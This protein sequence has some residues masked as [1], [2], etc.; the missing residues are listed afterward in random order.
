MVG[1]TVPGVFGMDE[2]VQDAQDMRKTTAQEQ[3]LKRTAA[4]EMGRI[5]GDADYLLSLREGSRRNT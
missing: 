2:V 5:P 3:S 1:S 4:R